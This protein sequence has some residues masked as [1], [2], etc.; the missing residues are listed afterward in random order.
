M[1][2]VHTLKQNLFESDFNVYSY[3]RLDLSSRLFPSDCPST[4]TD[5]H[6]FPQSV[7]GSEPQ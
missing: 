1:Y 4:L 6:V 7:Q 3:L 5:F 2:Q